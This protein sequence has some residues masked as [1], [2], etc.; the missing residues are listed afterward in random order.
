MG[1]EFLCIWGIPALVDSN[2]DVV[3]LPVLVG[4]DLL[5]LRE[6]LTLEPFGFLTLFAPTWGTQRVFLCIVC[7]PVSLHV[8]SPAVAPL[9]RKLDNERSLTSSF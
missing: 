4:I 9:V 2:E 7:I 5:K 3:D 1:G 8:E 6:K